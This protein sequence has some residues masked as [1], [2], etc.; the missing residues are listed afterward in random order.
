M[1]TSLE[2]S[3]KRNKERDPENQVP[4]IA[5]SVYTKHYNSPSVEEGFELIVL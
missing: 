2:V 5:Y 1:T 3:Y 4:K